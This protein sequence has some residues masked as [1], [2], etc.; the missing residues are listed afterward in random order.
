MIFRSENEIIQEYLA[1]AQDSGL[2]TLSED[3]LAQ[4]ENMKY[5]ENQYVL[6]ISTHGYISSDMERKIEEIYNNVDINTATGEGLD[7]IGRNRN[8]IRAPSQAA[9]VNL[10][11][12]DDIGTDSDVHIPAGTIV[13]IDQTVIP[14]EDEYVT[15]EDCTLHA[16]TL[17]TQVQAINTRQCFTKPVPEGT[18]LGL[19]GFDTLRVTI[20]KKGQMGV[21]LKKMRN[22][23]KECVHGR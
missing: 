19:V 18:V 3:I 1:Y 10:R 14:G 15:A 23:G 12:I 8:V 20:P 17:E 22:I 9:T 21:T 11:I 5:T 2:L 13:E 4:V 7:I 6:D 16:N